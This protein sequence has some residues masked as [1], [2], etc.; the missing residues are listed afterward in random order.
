V[1]QTRRRSSRGTRPLTSADIAKSAALQRFRAE[2]GMTQEEL[3]DRLGVSQGTLSDWERAKKPIPP[4]RFAAL[5]RLADELRAAYAAAQAQAERAAAANGAHEGEHPFAELPLE[6]PT[7]LRAN[8]PGAAG[9]PPP[10]FGLPPQDLPPMH[11]FG[12][13][14][15][16]GGITTDALPALFDVTPAQ[17]ALAVGPQVVYNLA[18]LALSKF[19]DDGAGQIVAGNAELLSVSLVQAGDVN[20]YI[21]RIVQLMQIGP[22]LNCVALHLTVVLEVISYL[23]AKARAAQEAARA[24]A[25]QAATAR[26]VRGDPFAAAQAA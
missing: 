14:M 17:R 19:V 1:S 3:A 5:Q 16:P 12:P 23:Q 20:P 6:P 18:G 2:S 21:A 10:G 8:V 7:E 22:V 4:D 24:S 25:E 11:P 9:E 13:P 15:A 26:A